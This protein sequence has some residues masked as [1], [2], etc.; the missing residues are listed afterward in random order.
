MKAGKRTG[1][2]GRKAAG[3]PVKR[4]VGWAAGKAKKAKAKPAPAGKQP[5]PGRTV[6]A[7]RRG[8]GGRPVG[9]QPRS[10]APG[11]SREGG[12]RTIGVF[13]GNARGFGFVAPD[14]AE[15]GDVFIPPQSTGGALHG[16]RVECIRYPHGRDG[17]PWGEIITIV[18]RSPTPII[19]YFNGRMVIPRD[20][21][22]CAWVKV[23]PSRAEQARPGDM[24]MVEVT[25][26]PEGPRGAEGR[27]IEVLGGHDEPGIESRI[28]LRAH[29]FAEEFPAEV[30]AQVADAP[31]T[32]RP[33]DL[34]GREDLRGIFTITIDPDR[35]RDFDDALGI[36]ALDSGWRVWVSIADV[37]HYAAAG[38]AL[39][40]E[41]YNRATSVYLPDRAIP[42]LP[43]ELSSGICSLRPHEDRLAVTVEMEFDAAGKR[44]RARYYT[45]VIRS[46]HRLTYD[47][48]EEMENSAEV[49]DRFPGAWEAV[50]PM[51]QLA[52]M[53]RRNR[54]KRGA[55]DLDMAEAEV[56]LDEDGRVVTIARRTQTWSHKLVEEFMLSANE[57]VAEWM[58][59]RE[60]KM[61]YRIHEPPA[62]QSVEALAAVLAPLG[63]QLLSRGAEP[64]HIKPGDYQ[65]VIRQA[66]GSRYEMMVKMLCLRSMM[67]ARY[68]PD[69]VGHFGLASDRY[70]HFTSPIRRYPDLIVHRLLKRELGAG[71]T[72]PAA[73]EELRPAAIHCSERERASAEAERDM[74][75]Y[76]SVRWMAERLGEDFSAVVTAANSQ[77]LWVE[78]EAAMVEG[79]IPLESLDVEMRFVETEMAVRGRG[80]DEV[81]RIGD[82]VRVWS[83]AVDIDRRRINFRLIERLKAGDS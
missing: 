56:V 76:Y 21:R 50:Q 42:M 67:Q 61:V 63:F 73:P 3:K 55:V 14:N 78:L 19:G 31:G 33:E 28:A 45:S 52:Q 9:G 54:L 32:V 22:F 82:R 11:R 70:C 16:D 27:I 44:R 74:V 39:D 71:G 1:K 72:L 48:V 5:P 24:V 30:L 10:F 83:E 20:P 43:P 66:Q 80:K 6:E 8:T 46:D 81:Y 37:S 2:S 38:T 23:R 69:L 47:Q 53:R 17:R 64:D 58:T 13:Q 77:G 79:L 62:P 41:A 12:L 25:S 65:R 29:G 36:A 40:A 75:D 34:V 15:I 51:R 26:W 59:D 7:A 68:S 60:M 4:G 18:E 49:R 57:A 35:A